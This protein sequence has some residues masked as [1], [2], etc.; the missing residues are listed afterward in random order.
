MFISIVSMYKIKQYLPDFYPK[1]EACLLYSSY[2][3]G[4]DIFCTHVP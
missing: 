2:R 3:V 4:F 1:T